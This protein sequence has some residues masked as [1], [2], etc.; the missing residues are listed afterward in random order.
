[1]KRGEGRGVWE[2][3]ERRGDEEGRRDEERGGE[4]RGSVRGRRRGDG[5]GRGVEERGGDTSTVCQYI[6]YSSC[7]NKPSLKTNNQAIILSS[8][9]TVLCVKYEDHLASYF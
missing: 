5:E 9:W 7:I 2:E 1:M 8:H 6:L 4:G 3:E